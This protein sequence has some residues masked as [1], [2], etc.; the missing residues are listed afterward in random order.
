VCGLELLSYAYSVRYASFF[1][2]CVISPTKKVQQ[3]SVHWL[4]LQ[5]TNTIYN[6]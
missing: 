3:N 1:I 5:L 6:Y 2:S 4:M